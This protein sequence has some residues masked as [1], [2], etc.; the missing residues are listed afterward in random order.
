MTIDVILTSINVI[1][2]SLWT[3]LSAVSCRVHFYSCTD[4]TLNSEP[5]TELLPHRHSHTHST[6]LITAFA[7][8]QQSNQL[9][10]L[11]TYP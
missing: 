6:Q 8:Y 3:L 1:I 5:I 2:I 7:L 9:A 11:S 10:A 4:Y